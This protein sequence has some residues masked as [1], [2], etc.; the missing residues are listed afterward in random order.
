MSKPN[1]Q[2]LSKGNLFYS[3]ASTQK[4]MFFILAPERE[5]NRAKEVK[6]NKLYGKTVIVSN[7]NRYS[8]NSTI[9]YSSKIFISLLKFVV[10]KNIYNEF[11]NYDSTEQFIY[12]GI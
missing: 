3:Y 4:E 9:T 1:Q 10:V 2:K 7:K 5:S 11:K 6:N 8:N 12:W